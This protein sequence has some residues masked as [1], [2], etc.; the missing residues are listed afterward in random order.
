MKNKTILTFF[1]FVVGSGLSGYFGPWWAPAVFILLIAALMGLHARQAIL[2]GSISL[3]IVFLVMA[4]WMNTLDDNGIIQ[5]TGMLL[6]GLSPLLMIGVTT[7]LGAITGG[8]SGW[9]GSA[10]GQAAVKK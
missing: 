10:L 8:L 9:L 4:A 5:K 2:A 7:L 3:G 1:L 6:G